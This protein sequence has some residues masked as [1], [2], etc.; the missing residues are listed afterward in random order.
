VV[1]NQIKIFASQQRNVSNF[2][3]IF[4]AEIC[5]N[6]LVSKTNFPEC[7][8]LHFVFVG[9]FTYD[10]ICNSNDNYDFKI[11][12]SLLNFLTSSSVTVRE[13]SI[14]LVHSY[15]NATLHHLA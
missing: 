13:Q 8:N 7:L 9:Y 15:H 1:Q 3:K 5:N 2:S 4:N 14:S 12:K 11:L 6:C 10:Q